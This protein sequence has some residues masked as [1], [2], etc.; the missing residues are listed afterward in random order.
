MEEKKG[1]WP[2]WVKIKR[3]ILGF[4]LGCSFMNGHYQKKHFS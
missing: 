3:K 1:G 4:D 2:N